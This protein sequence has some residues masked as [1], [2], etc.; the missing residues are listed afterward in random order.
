[1]VIFLQQ[2]PLSWLRATASN[3]SYFQTSR[4]VLVR[5]RVAG[6]VAVVDFK[7]IA[8]WLSRRRTY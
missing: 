5:L 8:A 3:N 7:S 1:M 6:V 4:D 2:L